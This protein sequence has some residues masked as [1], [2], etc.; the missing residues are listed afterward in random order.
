MD[1][2]TPETL[3]SQLVKELRIHIPFT[4]FGAFTGLI[5]FFLFRGLSRDTSFRI[6]YIL[7][8]LHVVFSAI[9]TTSLFAH[10][11]YRKHNR[12][13]KLVW[14]LIVGYVGAIGI[15]TL[16]DCLIPFLGETLLA[17]PEKDI[18]LG[19]IEKWWLVNPLALLGIAIAWYRPKTRIPHTGHVL[20]STYASLFHIIMALNGGIS[21]VSYL[22]IILFLFLAAWLPCCLSDI[23][24]PLML[25]EIKPRHHS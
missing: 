25:A 4:A 20:L 24:F 9:V 10:Y 18:H 7:H 8:P 6:F 23:I 14:L 12:R 13:V 2:D 21:V 3:F 5:L 15:A 16:S 17:L 11:R 1:A 22:I 19:F